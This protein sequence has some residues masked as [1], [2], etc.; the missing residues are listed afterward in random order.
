MQLLVFLP[1]YAD[2]LFS[3]YLLRV[4]LTALVVNDYVDVG[5]CFVRVHCTC[6]LSYNSYV[7]F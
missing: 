4:N 2:K 7:F 3:L 1:C 6:I 5:L